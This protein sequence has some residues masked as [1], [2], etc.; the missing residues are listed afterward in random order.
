MKKNIEIFF[1]LTGLFVFLALASCSNSSSS[2]SADKS[3]PFKG[4][5][6]VSYDSLGSGFFFNSDG[7]VVSK[8]GHGEKNGS[9]IYAQWKKQALGAYTYNSSSNT[10]VIK[11][12][13]QYFGD[14]LACTG[15]EYV[16]CLLDQAQKIAQIAGTSTPII[17]QDYKTAIKKNYELMLSN[18]N[19][20]YSCSIQNG[21]LRLSEDSANKGSFKYESGGI[22]IKFKC[23]AD[24]ANNIDISIKTSDGKFEEPIITEIGNGVFKGQD[25]ALN[26]S[27]NT[28]EKLGEFEGTYSISGGSC[29]FKLTSVTGSI[30]QGVKALSGIAYTLPQQTD[31]H[32]TL[33]RP[34]LKT[35]NYS[36]YGSDGIL[37]TSKAQTY[38]I[39]SSDSVWSL[40]SLKILSQCFVSGIYSDSA[41]A[42]S[43]IGKEIVDGSHVYVKLSEDSANEYN[44]FCGNFYEDGT[45]VSGGQQSFDSGVTLAELSNAIASLT[46][47]STIEMVGQ[48]TSS[49]MQTIADALHNSAWKVNL[50]L[51]KVTGLDRLT[52]WT[53]W[54]TSKLS[55]ILLPASVSKVEGYAFYWFD[56][57]ITVADNN[58][59]L[60]SDGGV[61][62]NKDKS[63]LIRCPAAKDG[64]YT[65]PNSVK[66]IG[67][68]AFQRCRITGITIP[69]SVTC[70]KYSAFEGCN[71]LRTFGIPAS[72]A[73]IEDT[74]FMDCT[75]LESITVDAGNSSYSVVDGVLFSK[76]MTLLV[77]C[78]SHAKGDFRHTYEYTIPNSVTVI[79]DCAFDWCEGLT[80]VFI[81]NSV[82]SVG[83]YAFNGCGQLSG[84]QIP[85]SVTSI[86]FAAFSASFNS[87][88]F[89]DPS[90]W[91]CSES[92]SHENETAIDLSNPSV[93]A[94][95][96]KE[97]G[98]YVWHFLYKKI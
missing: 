44:F 14:T 46:Q 35:I 78:P 11:V 69:N 62:F 94:T 38:L 13:G 79:G 16:N 53:S 7:T 58:P 60:T 89:A 59:Y 23:P 84:I 97:D 74:V 91:Y 85:A 77:C 64:V 98:P 1:V 29:N 51:Q 90:N 34:V 49:D 93:N 17:S 40:D 5:S 48:V 41:L 43:I 3:D 82:T 33:C 95:N 70:I 15:D 81:P 26:S 31:S 86:G 21:T 18:P 39:D 25:F 56:A 83:I 6:Y 67:N 32:I 24:G 20:Q 73:N 80:N 9:T 37:A 30:A 45:S 75:S 61:L 8:G 36:V 19:I 71:L 96:L 68:R 52:D 47:D 92:S 88:E 12:L 57:D 63:I 50:D 66:T 2:P 72:V 54:P 4:Q 55:G 87:I 76:D 22:K 42:T 10:L 28:L 65:I 27:T